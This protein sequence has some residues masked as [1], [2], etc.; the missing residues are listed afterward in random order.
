MKEVKR[1][2]RMDRC[3]HMSS[4]MGKRCEKVEKQGEFGILVRRGNKRNAGRRI[5]YNGR[6]V[7]ELGLESLR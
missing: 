5:Y 1:D 6:H 3:R 7:A 4:Q 2:K